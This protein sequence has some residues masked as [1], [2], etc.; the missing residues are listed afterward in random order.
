LA[1]L[2]L[3]GMEILFETGWRNFNTVYKDL[4]DSWVLY[5]NSGERPVLLDA[6]GTQ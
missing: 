5:D 1:E 6:G 2:A 4:A 3:H